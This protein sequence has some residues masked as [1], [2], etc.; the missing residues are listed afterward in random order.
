VNKS[1]WKPGDTV[2][3]RGTGFR[4]LWWA[5]P[6]TVVRDSPEMVALYWQVGTHWRDIGRHPRGREFLTIDKIELQELVW[7][8][9]DVLMLKNPPEAHSIWLM[10]EA[11]QTRLDC[12]YVNL[13][14]PLRR[15]PPGFDIMDH[16]LDIVIRPDRSGW[17][18]KDEDAF[19]EMVTA[20]VFTAKEA[21]AIREEGERVIRKMKANE[22]PF[23]D[24]WEKWAPPPEWTIPALPPDWE[25]L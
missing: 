15:T 16:E 13:E 24:G 18:W 10:W 1:L 21:R 23:C 3:L 12:W 8:R 2:V 5:M 9:T 7:N 19:E 11:G 14:T 6:V 4:R 22:P 25:Q 17:H 20:G